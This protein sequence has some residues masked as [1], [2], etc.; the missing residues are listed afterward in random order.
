MADSDGAFEFRLLKGVLELVCNKVAT[1]GLD[2]W[3][4]Q[5]GVATED[6]FKTNL[7]KCEF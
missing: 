3:K 7:W 1:Y 6:D 2:M 5:V 4:E